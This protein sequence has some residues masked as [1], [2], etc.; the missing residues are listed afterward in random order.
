[1]R[2]VKLALDIEP[3]YWAEQPMVKIQFNEQVLHEGYMGEH[4]TF[5]WLLPAADNNRISVFLLNKTDRDTVGDKD[6]AVI[7]K[8]I[9]IEG[10]RYSSFMLQTQYRPV[11]TKGYY[12]YAKENNI[13]VQPIVKSNYLG[14]NGEWYLEFTWPV[15]QWIFQTETQGMG[16][17]YEKNI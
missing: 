6:K 2:D 15:Y 7:I 13:K 17:I 5:E 16:W 4:K 9:G 12:Q 3:I 11:Y 8:S 10:F 1:M 14:F